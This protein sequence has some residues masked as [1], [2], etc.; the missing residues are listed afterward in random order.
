MRDELGPRDHA[1]AV[2]QFR[3]Q[4]V[5]HLLS[6]DL[7]HGELKAELRRLAKIRRRPPGWSRTRTFGVSSLERWY[8][9]YKKGGL[10]ALR[11]RRRCDAGHARALTEAQRALLLDIR[12]E[13]P[14]AAAELI[15]RTLEYDGRLQA[16]AVSASTVRRLFRE[17]GMPRRS[18]QQK[19][20]ERGARQRWQAE[21]AGLL[22]HA[23]V[24][25]GPTLELEGKRTPLRIHA[26]L[27]DA[28]RY[29]V[30]L[31]VC[32]NEREVEMLELM[33]R[34]LRRWGAP[35]TLYLDN[36]STYTGDMLATA[37]ARLKVSLIHARPYDPQAR[38]K[39]ERFWRTMRQGCLDHLGRVTRLHDV[40]VRLLAW[41][42]GHYHQA[43]H[44]GL[45]GRT[46]EI[47]WL[48]RELQAIDEPTLAAALTAHGRRRVRQDG[49]LSV[50]GLDWETEQGFLAGRLVRIERNL[51]EPMAPPILVH[52]GRR[53]PL[54]LVDPVANGKRRRSFKPKPGIDAVEFD[55]N[56]VLLDSI[57]GRTPR[58]ER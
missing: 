14:S 17:E 40:Q 11:P 31:R 54:R 48:E 26:I 37:C 19:K 52:E 20:H 8:Y 49:T 36:G 56:Q 27:D 34:A 39:M 46:P 50:G 4:I 10:E 9:A 18:R 24:C 3:A 5:G 43:P 33:T 57:F 15:V 41:L 28:S 23:D 51:V 1:E 16:G 55:P 7:A 58:S 35:G 2:A 30:A 12:R 29:I 13:H 42:D 47:V 53:Y 38:G 44:G 6:Q 22:W 21:R 45:M 25:H 32:S